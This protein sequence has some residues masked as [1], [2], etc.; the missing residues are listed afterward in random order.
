VNDLRSYVAER[1]LAVEATRAAQSEA[2]SALEADRAALRGRLEEAQGARNEKARKVSR[3]LLARYDR[4]QHRQ[5]SVAL[6]ALR[7][8]S[9]GNCDTMI[10]MQRRNVM[11]GTGEPEVCEG[12]GVLLYADSQ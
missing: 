7:G 8:Q 12:C 9:C 5:R 4:I 6:F 1:E 2:R 3:G 11:L 10:P